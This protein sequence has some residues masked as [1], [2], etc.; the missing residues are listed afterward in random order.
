MANQSSWWGPLALL[1]TLGATPGGA[2]ADEKQ[3]QPS[4][5][6]NAPSGWPGGVFTAGRDAPATH[7]ALA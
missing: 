4:K 6:S 7:P 3:E 5:P 1:V 2:P